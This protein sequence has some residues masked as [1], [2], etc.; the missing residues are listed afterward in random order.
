M[1]FEEA[2]AISRRLAG[3]D[4]SNAES[5]SGLAV[6]VGSRKCCNAGAERAQ[7]EQALAIRRRLA[8][9]DPSNA[10]WQSAWQTYNRVGGAWQGR[11]RAK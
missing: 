5:Q 2:V 1:G 10:D 4:P 8:Q 6:T 7:V 9:Q 11:G 3:D